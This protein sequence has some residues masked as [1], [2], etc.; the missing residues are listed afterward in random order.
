LICALDFARVM[1]IKPTEEHT[2][3]QRWYN[4]VSARASAK[5]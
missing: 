1:K 5:A 3:L 2:H 4:D